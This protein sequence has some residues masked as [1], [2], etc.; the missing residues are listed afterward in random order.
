MDGVK[1]SLDRRGSMPISLGRLCTGVFVLI[2]LLNIMLLK[3]NKVNVTSHVTSAVV[4]SIR[5]GVNGVRR[6]S[7]GSSGEAARSAAHASHKYIPLYLIRSNNFPSEEPMTWESYPSVIIAG[8]AKGGTTDLYDTLTQQVTHPNI[9]RGVRKETNA[10]VSVPNA[11]R[12][13]ESLLNGSAPGPGVYT[14][15][16]TPMYIHN[17][18]VVDNVMAAAPRAKVVVLLRNEVQRAVSLYDHWVLGSLVR[19]E[20]TFDS[21]CDDFF[22]IVERNERVNRI[23]EEVKGLD[24]TNTS[25]WDTISRL[26]RNVFSAGGFNR[27]A[28]SIFSAGLYKYQLIN[29]AARGNPRN[30]LVLSSPAYYASRANVI[31]ALLK[32]LMYTSKEESDDDGQKQQQALSNSQSERLNAAGVSNAHKKKKPTEPSK[33][34]LDRMENFYRTHNKGLDSLLSSDPSVAMLAHYGFQFGSTNQSGFYFG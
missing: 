26:Y 24:H 6:P 13:K 20:R 23:L 11:Q 9:V 7:S 5:I 12:Y 27:E 3:T 2:V 1:P 18:F 30:I 21:I 33:E 10:L 19:R 34:C 17:P 22:G 31:E 14:I 29:W 15:D 25:H 32:F 28:M 4:A 8:V 16:A